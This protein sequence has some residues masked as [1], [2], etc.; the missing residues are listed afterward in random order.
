MMT[1]IAGNQSYR[2]ELEVARLIADDM[3]NHE[4]ATKL[5]LS[6]RTVEI[7]VTHMF[8]KLGLHL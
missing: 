8:N 3:S 7:H 5:F 2:R 1:V 6:E 4:I